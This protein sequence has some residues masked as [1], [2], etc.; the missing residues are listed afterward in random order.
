MNV[1]TMC[2]AHL[3]ILD[4]VA[5]WPGSSHDSNILLNSKIYSRFV[6]KEFKNCV[7]VADSGYPNK[8]FIMTPLLSV[9]NEAENLYNESQIRTRNCI[10]RS[11][12]VWKRRFPILSLGIRLNHK[13]VEG[14]IVATAVLHNK[15][16][17]MSPQ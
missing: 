16:T 15:Q 4:V 7:I 11:Y 13:K 3:R 12:G 17:V 6:S 9:K 14:I 10:E 2:D 1:Q 5:R 8:D